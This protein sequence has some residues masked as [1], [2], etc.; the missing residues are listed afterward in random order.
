MLALALGQDK[1][2]DLRNYH[3]YNAYAFL[4]DRYALD[5]LPAQ[6]PSFYNPLMDVPFFELATHV[7]ARAAAFVLGCVQ[8]LNFILLFA[9]AYAT[10]IVPNA[11][12]KVIVCGALA[13]LGILGGGGIALIGTTFGDN[14]TSLG[15]LASAALIVRHLERLTL[16]KPSRVFGLAFCFALPMGL[17]VGLKLP[18]VIYAVGLCGGLLF[19]GGWRRGF[20]LSFAFGLGILAGMAATFGPWGYFL[21]T[22]YGSPFFPYFNGLFHSPLA[23]PVSGRDVEYVPHSWSE[24]FTL[25]FIFGRYPFRVGEIEWRD[26][27]IP[28]LYV[29]LPLAVMLRLFFGRSRAQMDAL[30]TRYAARYLLAAFAIAYAVWLGMFGIYRYAVTLEMIAPLLIVFAVGMLPL[31]ISTRALVAGFMLAIVSASIHAG[32]WGRRTAWLDRFVEARI[33]P[34]GD[35]SHLMILMAGIEPYS[36]LIPEFPPEIG[37]TR[38]ESNFSAPDQD[39]GI[40]LLIHRRVDAHRAAGGRFLMLIPNWQNKVA[41]EALGYFG[42]RLGAGACQSVT[43]RLNNDMAMNLC[44]VEN[45]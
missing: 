45:K 31:K 11:R 35:T 9:L 6:T 1:N 13:A 22:R 7:S 42:L 32:D 8:G 34:L 21:E 23:P 36:H 12:H 29:L 3:Y 33:P 41:D 14:I 10:L 2:W 39:K 25:P 26:W 18:C 20:M 17:M 44:P 15:V 40:N 5:L 30:A 16:D 4:N 27:R 43:D 37:F 28:M 24:Y 19:V 38:I